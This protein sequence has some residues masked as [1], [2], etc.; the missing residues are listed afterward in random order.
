MHTF[1]E[2]GDTNE[3]SVVWLED[4][5]TLK[6]ALSRANRHNTT[7]RGVVANKRGLGVR[8]PNGDFMDMV[9]KFVNPMS[10][11]KEIRRQGQNIYEVSRAPPWLDADELAMTL[12]AQGHGMWIT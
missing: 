4:E 12:R 5:I 11:A 6:E 1:M 8:V 10:A 2:K 9:G 3:F 7:P